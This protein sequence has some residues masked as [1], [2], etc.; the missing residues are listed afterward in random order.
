MS[1]S[2]R[3]RRA[4]RSA[5]FGWI[6]GGLAV[7]PL[8]L[9]EAIRNAAFGTRLFGEMLG[10]SITLWTLLSLAVSCYC[11]CLF[12]LPVIWL[13]SPERIAA[14]RILWTALNAGFGFLLMALRA[15][16]WTAFDHDGV[17]STNFWIWALFATVFF[18]V[19]A[20]SYVRQMK[21]ILD[22]PEPAPSQSQPG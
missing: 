11:L 8:Q 3:F 12:L 5:L 14:H 6:A 20:E 4:V 1:L 9:L 15:H 18:G 19:A 17:G 21:R 2:F 13:F 16:V 22:A 10:L 7:L